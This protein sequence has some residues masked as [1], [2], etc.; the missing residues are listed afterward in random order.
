MNI[1]TNSTSNQ[2]FIGIDVSKAELEV[3][4]DQTGLFQ[5]C[6]NQKRSLTKLAKQLKKLNPTLI[7]LEATGGYET[8]AATIFN[9][10][11]IAFAIVYPRRVRQFAL[12]LGIM[13]KTDKIDARIIAYYGRIAG[14]KPKPLQ[15]KEVLHL[16]ALTRRRSQL[17]EMRLMEEN[18]LETASPLI[19]R[20]IKKHIKYL[21]KQIEQLE[22]EIANQIETSETW[23]ETDQ[24]L[25]AVPGVGPVLSSTLITQLPELGSI[26]NKQIASLVGV[27][28]FSSESGKY[29]G[30]RFCKG[31]R[32]S[33]RRVLYM[34]TMNATQHNPII[35]EFYD[36]L[37][38]RGKLKKVA[39][40]ACARKLLCILNA[41]VRN[42]TNW[43]PKI[44]PISA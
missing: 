3:F 6:P 23:N 7:V 14:I 21:L 9:D 34:A 28:P 35:K 29:K 11:D 42:K 2:I 40:I 18:R 4:N 19:S 25:R 10:L 37:L 12:G 5:S 24:R 1:S 17:I 32:N 41:M 36:R 15:S 27:A 8:L 16:Q 33:I 30:Q 44:E 39:I 38:K 26:S 31:G 13:A 43:S 22:S 20:I